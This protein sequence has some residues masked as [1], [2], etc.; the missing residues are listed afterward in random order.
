MPFIPFPSNVSVIKRV[1]GANP[2]ANAEVSDA[3]PAG[4]AWFLMSVSVQLVQGATQTP[5]PSLTI[6]DGANILFQGFAGTAAV[7]A[8]TTTQVTWAANLPASGAAAS[9]ATT[10]PLPFGLVLL[11]GYRIRTS[12][13]GIGANTDY[14]IPSYFVCELG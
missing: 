14:G 12:T 9:T 10:G 7:S 3:V 13:T 8:A 5:F 1:A 6:D 4:K 11:A 2:A